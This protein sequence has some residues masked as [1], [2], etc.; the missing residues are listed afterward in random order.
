MTWPLACFLDVDA[1]CC[2]MFHDASFVV[3]ISYQDVCCDLVSDGV[4]GTVRLW[5]LCQTDNKG[6]IIL[7]VDVQWVMFA[8]NCGCCGCIMWP[9]SSINVAC[10]AF[11]PQ[12]LSISVDDL[13]PQ[14]FG[15]NKRTRTASA[16]RKRHPSCCGFA[17]VENQNDLNMQFVLGL[18]TSR[19]ICQQCIYTS[20]V[21]IHDS[22]KFGSHKP[23]SRSCHWSLAG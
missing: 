5:C 7:D 22:W 14:S 20:K 1:A 2:V 8:M 13:K 10:L 23:S 9:H 17:A 18:F 19:W 11:S 15:G 6:I 21:Q 4:F 3:I 12:G 16:M